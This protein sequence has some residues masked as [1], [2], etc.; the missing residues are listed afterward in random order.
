[1]HKYK[2]V[3]AFGSNVGNRI[4]NFNKSLKLLEEFVKVQFQSK[5]IETKPLSHIHYKT[6][7]HEN[8]LNFICI[9]NSDLLPDKLY[10]QIAQIE[11]LIGHPRE[12]RWMPRNLDIDLLFC[13]KN[14]AKKFSECT[15]FP[16]KR[17][18]NFH[19]PHLDYFNRDFWR[20]ILENE[21]QV[22]ESILINHFKMC[23]QQKNLDS[24]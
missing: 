14:D 5:W 16:F 13:A 6:D 18:P 24:L 12:R 1:M 22:H 4:E 9:A 10:E 3:L 21:L 20:D 19:V 8:Y 11:D 17:Q 23:S 2:Y 15:P 7:D